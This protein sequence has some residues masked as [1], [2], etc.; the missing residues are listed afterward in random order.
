MTV[1]RGVELGPTPVVPSASV[2]LLLSDRV[3]SHHSDV[4]CCCCLRASPVSIGNDDIEHLD[5][6]DV[7]TRDN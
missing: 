3:C 6:V 4:G 7:V 1:L 2:T 5:D